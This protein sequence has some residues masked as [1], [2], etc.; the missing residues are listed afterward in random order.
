MNKT[1]HLLMNS[2]MEMVTSIISFSGYFFKKFFLWVI[3][4][5]DFVV[6]S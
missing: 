2:I 6:K 5:H 4:S 1:S 3:K